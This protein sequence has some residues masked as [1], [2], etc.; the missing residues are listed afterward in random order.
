[1]SIRSPQRRVLNLALVAALGIVLG[2]GGYFAY[3]RMTAPG[4]R[5]APAWA[6][7]AEMPNPRGET[8]MAVAGGLVYVA[9]GYIGLGFET[10]GIVSVYD[11][12]ADQWQDG[13]A[14]PQPRNHAAAIELD[15]TIYVSGG[16]SPQ[17]G[18]TET[19]W[20]LAPGAVA[21]T[22]LPSMRGQRSGH[23]MAA[24]GG[25][26]YVVGGVGAPA[27]GP[28]AVGRVLIY[29]VAT[30]AWSDGAPMPLGRDHLAVVVVGDEIWAIGGRAG[31][32]NHAMVDIYDPS[33]DAWRA[34]P[35]LPEGTSGAAEAIVDGV[36]YVS[37]GEDPA[38]G[39]I[40]DRHWR[41]DT[42]LGD[43]ATWARLAP[44]PLAVHG[45]PG[46]ELDGQFTIIAGSTR[47]GGE[48][49]TAWT[50]AT[51][52]LVGIPE[53][54]GQP[55]RSCRAIALS[56]RSTARRSGSVASSG[57]V[58]RMESLGPKAA[59]MRRAVDRRSRSASSRRRSGS[60]SR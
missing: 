32:Q 27:D 3:Q 10:T 55:W 16:A 9:G 25:R 46:V 7:L 44:P 5:S 39:E 49:S 47:P 28:G 42:S 37:G 36:I 31:G 34:G 53:G 2:V 50:G 17:G 41:L 35:P 45:V 19:V 52:V 33:T 30:Q 4:P 56:S 20:A 18:A 60:G 43:A 6:L 59:R 14:L 51:Q 24:L 29:D 57:S 38:R 22:E 23:R 21:W 1:M 8:A 58:S 12:A 26:V 40:V 15:G 54:P 48:S 11:S 13:P